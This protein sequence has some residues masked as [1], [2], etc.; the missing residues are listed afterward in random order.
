MT[1]KSE[2]KTR[3]VTV[4]RPLQTSTEYLKTGDVHNRSPDKRLQTLTFNMKR[5]DTDRSNLGAPCVCVVRY[6]T[7]VADVFVYVFV[8]LLMWTATLRTHTQTHRQHK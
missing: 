5:D 4:Q 7:Y 6:S 2:R 3:S 8:R 1:C